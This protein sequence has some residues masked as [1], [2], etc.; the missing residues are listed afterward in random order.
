M[1]ELKDLYTRSYQ[2]EQELLTLQ[3]D[4]KELRGEFVY[5]KEYNPSG[6]LKEEVV[7]TMKAAKAKAKQDNLQEKI[8]E[9]T[10]IGEIQQMYSMY[11]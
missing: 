4:L 2:L 5:H 7:K 11:S 1:K 6:Y 10:E 8:E 9:L 3:E